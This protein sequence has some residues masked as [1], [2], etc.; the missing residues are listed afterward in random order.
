[1]NDVFAQQVGPAGYYRWIVTT[2]YLGMP[3][4]FGDR[5][6][7]LDVG[8]HNG[9]FLDRIDAGFKVGLDLLERPARVQAW[10]QADASK[11]PFVVNSFEQVMAFD[12]IEHIEQDAQVLREI[13]RVLKPGGTFWFSTPC[14]DFYLFPGGRLQH[15]F[16]RAWGHV[17]RGYT[18]SELERKLPA[19]LVGEFLTW[20]EPAFRFLYILIKVMH[21]PSLLTSRR[22][23]EW[24]YAWDARHAQGERGHWFARLQK[25]EV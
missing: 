24:A 15:R 22:F 19:C 16:E 1:M 13:A 3:T 2:Q 20:N 23:M 11:L 5:T 14:A 8:A 25:T 7:I 18:L 10:T 9:A 12:I 21:G 6:S 4:H 17:R